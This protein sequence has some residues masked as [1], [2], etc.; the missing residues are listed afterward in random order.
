ML[1]VDDHP[2][3][4]EGLRFTLER[5]GM[6]VVGEAGDGARGARLAADDRPDVVVMDLAMP[7]LDGLA[8]TQPLRRAPAPRCWC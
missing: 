8:A 1:L 6:E 2:M 7:V 4:R 5:A 3:F